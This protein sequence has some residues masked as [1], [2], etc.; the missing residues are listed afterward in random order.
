MNICDLLE[1]ICSENIWTSNL[2]GKFPRP[3]NSKRTSLQS[4][5]DILSLFRVL[6]STD[7]CVPELWKLSGSPQDSSS[8]DV[9]TDKFR[10]IAAL[11]HAI[12]GEHH[13][14]S[15]K[16]AK[17]SDLF[18]VAFHLRRVSKNF[19]EPHLFIRVSTIILSN[20]PK[21]TFLFRQFSLISIIVS[22]WE[23][24]GK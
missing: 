16:S 7:S 5:P 24:S 9:S 8:I 23:I 4:L 11:G 6:G 18:S 22:I 1:Q 13:V 3:Q 19:S 15:N 21:P 20:F 2:L 12:S 17:E 10:P 14:A